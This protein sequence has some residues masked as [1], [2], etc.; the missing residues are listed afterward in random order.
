MSNKV[1]K[2]TLKANKAIKKLFISLLK[3]IFSKQY[4]VYFKENKTENGNI[5]YY[6]KEN[7]LEG[8][9]FNLGRLNDLFDNEFED[10]NGNA[11]K[12]IIGEAF[13]VIEKVDEDDEFILCLRANFSDELGFCYVVEHKDLKKAGLTKKLNDLHKSCKKLFENNSNIGVQHV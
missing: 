4:S 1:N 2:A 8:D 5:G 6:P 10:Y 12:W 7:I 9:T 11:V 3:E 13:L